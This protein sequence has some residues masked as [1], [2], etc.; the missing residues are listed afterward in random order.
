MVHAAPQQ[1]CSFVPLPT[2]AT[3]A[4]SGAIAGAVVVLGRRAIVD[5]PTAIVAG[6][7]LILLLRSRVAEPLVVVGA[8]LVGLLLAS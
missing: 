6:V 4:S 1:C 7:S 3:A 8:G 5:G 2:G